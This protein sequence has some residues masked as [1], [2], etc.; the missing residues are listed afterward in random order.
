MDEKNCNVCNELLKLT[1]TPDSIHYGKLECPNCGFKGFARR[2]DSEKIGTTRTLRVGKKEIKDVLNFHKL[3]KEMCFLC[4]RKRDQLGY[5]ETLTIDHIDELSRGG[6][7]IIENMQILCTACHQLK[8][9]V[10]LYGHWHFIK[11]GGND[12]SQDTSKR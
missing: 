8:N 4:L 2:P 3:T 10:R 5:R 6:E 12:N 9:W 7:D 11:R 1:L